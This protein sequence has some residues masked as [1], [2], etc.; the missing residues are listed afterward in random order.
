MNRV[1]VSMAAA[2]S[3]L[4]LVLLGGGAE[5]LTI[6]PVDRAEILAGSK[7]DLKVEFDGVVASGD[8]RVAV[9]GVDHAVLLGRPAQFIAREQGVDA[10]ALLLRD[11]SLTKPGSYAVVATDGKTTRTVTWEVYATGPRKARNVIL[12]IGDGMSVA[13]RT[14]ARILSKSITEGKYHG[15]LAMDTMPSM[16]LLGTSGVDSIITDSANSAS[17]YTTGHKSSVN[18]LG[19]YAD[20]TPDSLDDPKVETIT[21]LVKRKLGMAVGVVT[22]TEV[23]DAT[24]AAMVAHTR[25]RADYDP[26]VGMLYE[27]KVDVLMG[28]GAAHFIPK[29][30]PGSRRRDELNYVEMFR[31]AGYRIATTDQEMKAAA[32]DGGTT[33]LLGLFHPGNMDG[34]LDRKFLKKGTVKEFPEQPDLVDQVKSALEVLSRSDK[35]F[36]LMVESGLIDKYSHPLDWER[37]VIDTIM[38]DKAVEVAKAFATPRGDTL[39]MVTADHSH[40]LAIVGTV[41]DNAKGELMRD[42]VGVYERAGYP[43]YVKSSEDGYP[44]RLDVSKRLAIFFTAFPDYYETWRPKLDGPFVPA[45]AGAD[46]LYVANEQFRNAPGAVLRTGNLPRDAPQGVHSGEDVV[47]TAMGPGAEAVRGFM[48]N[49]EVFRVMVNAL[50]LG[51]ESAP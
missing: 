2:L 46:K 15:K 37:A 48:D 33:R 34:A 28:G 8:V 40:G 20:R 43:S 51:Q 4:S 3:T 47:L 38:L 16:A 14:A 19:V 1:I 29:N 12:F 17:A 30:V 44:E 5:A 11:V 18:A 10:S 41:D 35:G 9:N 7:F 25:R 31:D 22:N 13:H 21:S 45:V 42:K 6:Y 32:A 39:V 23:E 24:P 49:T 50:G 36:V 27:S 26:I